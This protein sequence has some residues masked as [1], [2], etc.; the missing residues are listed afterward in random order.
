MWATEVTHLWTVGERRLIP[1]FR[2]K[3]VADWIN[4]IVVEL[5]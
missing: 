1:P 3:N 2:K 4:F 5:P